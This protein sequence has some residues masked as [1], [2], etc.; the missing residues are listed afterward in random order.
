MASKLYGSK[1]GNASNGRTKETPNPKLPEFPELHMSRTRPKEFQPLNKAQERYVNLIE[2]NTITFGIGPAGTGKTLVAAAIAARKF[3]DK[4]IDKIIITRPIVE[5]GEKLG[6]LPGEMNDKTQ[7]YAEPIIEALSKFMGKSYVEALLEHEKIVFLP[8]AFMR[9]WTF[10]RSMVILDEAQ[11]VTKT[12]MK[13]FLTRVGKDA[14]VVIDGDI[15][16][17]DIEADGL[18]DAIY[19]L[20]GIP[21][22]GVMRFTAEDIV[23]SGIVKDIIKA[24]DGG[25]P[26][27]TEGL[28]NYLSK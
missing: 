17:Q 22:I 8:L 12:Q 28:K 3:K 19:R 23:R 13:L 1:R 11:N 21:S 10:E 9:G 14:T 7:P 24:Y 27:E 16:Q 5:A 18:Y 15:T 26:S 25:Y 6:F 2:N 20:D 4:K